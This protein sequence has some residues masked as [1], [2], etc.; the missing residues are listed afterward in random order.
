MTGLSRVTP[1]D[2]THLSDDDY[3][4]ATMFGFTNDRVGFV[5]A[6][7]HVLRTD[8]S[9]E[10]WS[11]R[12][13]D[14]VG[15]VAG[16]SVGSDKMGTWVASSSDALRG[17]GAR[18]PDAFLPRDPDLVRRRVRRADTCPDRRVAV[19]RRRSQ[20]PRR[21]ADRL[22]QDPRRVPV[23][24]RPARHRAP[25][26][27]KQH[28]CRVL[29][30]SPLKAL[31]V[32]VERNLRAPLVGIA[33]DG[34]ATRRRRARHHRR[35]PL[36]RHLGA[37]RRKLST[38]PPDILITTPE[39]LFLMLTSQARESLRGVE[40]VIVDEVHAVAGT[41]RGAHLALSLER[42][43]ELLDQ[44]GAA[45]RAV[46][47][48]A[49]D[50]RGG[51]VPRRRAAGRGGRA[52]VAQA[53][54][55]AGRRAG[56]GHDRARRPSP[57][58]S[59]GPA[60]GNAPRPSIWPHVEERIVDLIE[61]HRSTIVFANSRRL[62]E[63]LT[64]RL[65]EIAAERA[66]RSARRGR[67]Q[68]AADH[69]A[70]RRQPR[71]RRASSPGPPRLGEQGAARARSRTTSRPAGCPASSPPRASSSAS[72]W[73]PSTSSIQVESPP[74]VASG[75]QRVGRAGHQV[76]EISRGVLFPKHRADLVQT[77]VAV[78][79]MRA[80]QIE[81]LKVPANPLDVLAQQIVACTSVRSRDVDDA[82]R[83]GPAGCSLRDAAPVGVR[84][85]PRPAVGALPVRRV[86]RAAAAAGLGPRG[87]HADRPARRAAAGRHLRR[88]DPRPR[89]VRCLPGRRRRRCARRSAN[90]TRRWSTSRASATSS[91]SAP[92]AGGS[93]TS[94]TT[95]CSSPPRPASPD[96]CR[97]GRATRSAGR[98]SSVRPWARFVREVAKLGRRGAIARAA[99]GGP[100]RPTPP[101]TWSAF[102]TEQL[103]RHRL[104][105][106]TTGSCW[107]SA[108]ATSSAT[109]G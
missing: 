51:A 57:T 28:R 1:G 86:R 77:A 90:S 9:G 65:N 41:K 16:L 79:R 35:R 2:S 76:G 22:R 26:D 96:G 93:R 89:P 109:G 99:H 78:E 44:P 30:I 15:T 62:A 50:R 29:Y 85:D 5:I 8:D 103:S 63:R 106:C 101:P 43:D 102:V 47:D 92:R 97:S 42:L 58:T 31:A 17:L 49:A 34:R 3:T 27:D 98:P 71:G 94:P 82:V 83:P 75:L 7:G 21:R 24:A 88:H 11:S 67:G 56:R 107:S 54:G 72:T 74:S 13:R 84:R 66:R 48:R 4:D 100:R 69:G 91:R 59:K 52:D 104:R 14:T 80:G 45:H 33:P 60:A 37:D 10:T 70:E 36:R 6:D 40:T 32:D 108:A 68:P 12:R 39:S 38:T 25:A 55:P 53:V 61:Q 105:P 73:A 19:D 64:A 87:Q 23:G 18:A 95:G 46:G 20:R 81:A